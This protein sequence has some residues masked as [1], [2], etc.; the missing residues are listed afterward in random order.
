MRILIPFDFRTKTACVH[1]HH[2][3]IKEVGLL[4]LTVKQ[5]LWPKRGQMSQINMKCEVLLCPF[6]P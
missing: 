2:S 3:H 4:E 5:F 6:I 1:S